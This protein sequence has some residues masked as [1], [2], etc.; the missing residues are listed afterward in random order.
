MILIVADA[1]S[2]TFWKDTRDVLRDS[3][4][5]VETLTEDKPDFGKRL[6]ID[7]LGV[8]GEVTSLGLSRLFELPDGLLF[9]LIFPVRLRGEIARRPDVDPGQSLLLELFTELDPL[10]PPLSPP[11]I[12]ELEASVLVSPS[13]REDFDR[14]EPLVFRKSRAL[15]I[16]RIL[17]ML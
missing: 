17:F 15:R 8:P 12:P 5:L 1:G 7:R 4:D 2:A 11:T 14:F 16:S 3:G 9:P 13:R 10:L 6:F